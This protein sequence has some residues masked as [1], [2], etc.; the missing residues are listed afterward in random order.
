MDAQAFRCNAVNCLLPANLQMELH[1]PTGIYIVTNYIPD[2]NFSG[3]KLG[4]IRLAASWELP[5]LK[6]VA[7]LLRGDYVLHDGDNV[8]KRLP[9]GEIRF[10]VHPVGPYWSISQIQ[11]GWATFSPEGIS[12]WFSLYQALPDTS[13]SH[14]VTW[15]YEL[16]NLGWAGL[17]WPPPP[18][19]PPLDSTTYADPS[20]SLALAPTPDSPTLTPRSSASDASPTNPCQQFQ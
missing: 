20:P 15:Q 4:D 1:L 19:Y 18:H 9:T 6:V 3:T 5:V 10:M 12:A 2:G 16:F 17:P 8:S 14:S 7:Y 13:I 11:S